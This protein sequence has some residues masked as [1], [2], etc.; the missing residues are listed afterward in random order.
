M[1]PSKAR[2]SSLTSRIENFVVRRTVIGTIMRRTAP[3]ARTTRN[4]TRRFTNGPSNG[5]SPC[6]GRRSQRLKGVVRARTPLRFGREERGRRILEVRGLL[7]ASGPGAGHD[8]AAARALHFRGG[9][10]FGGA[11]PAID[12]GLAARRV[13]EID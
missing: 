12:L 3:T 2:D 9:A 10:F 8:H 13:A 6:I 11:H 1:R 5:S 4:G 7:L